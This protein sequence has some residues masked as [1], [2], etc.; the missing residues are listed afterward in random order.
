MP[1]TSREPT[2]YE[3]TAELLAVCHRDIGRHL[4][5]LERAGDRADGDLEPLRKALA[6]FD[7]MLAVHQ[8]DE[9]IDV[10]PALLAAAV[11]PDERSRA[12]ELVA[13]LMVEH[14]ELS[15][16]WLALR[17]ALARLADGL[18]AVLPGEARVR[19]A[20]LYRLHLGREERELERLLRLVPSDRLERIARSIAARHQRA[21]FGGPGGA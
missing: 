21:G 1:E 10:F 5:A 6:F 16:L 14:R 15:A 7:L 20:A 19:F 17:P 12:Y 18:D 9:E 11:R 3:R 2:A 13:R 4:E 8:P